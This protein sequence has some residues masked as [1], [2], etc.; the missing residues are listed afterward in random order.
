MIIPEKDCD[1]DTCSHRATDI[2]PSSARARGLNEV[3]LRN[4][5]SEPKHRG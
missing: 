5:A 4:K 1:K 2:V 3:G